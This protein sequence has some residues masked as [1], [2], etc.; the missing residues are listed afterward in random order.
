MSQTG[1]PAGPDPHAG[2][3]AA[4]DLS[5]NR[6]DREGVEAVLNTLEPLM[7]QRLRKIW[8]DKGY[9]S[10]GLRTELQALGIELE[11]VV[12]APDQV[13]FAVQPHRWVVE[14][15][16]AWFSQARRLSKDYECCPISS[17]GMIYLA[18]IRTL[19]RRLPE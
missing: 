11:I 16:F 3:I 10:E 19:L 17:E 6:S 13:G 1:S 4:P 7:A 8:A 2:Y 12:A 14:R 5:A 9:Q 18:A 15:T